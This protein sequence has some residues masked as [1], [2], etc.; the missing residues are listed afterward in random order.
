[1][2]T[3]LV[4]FLS[5]TREGAAGAVSLVIGVMSPSYAMTSGKYKNL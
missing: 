1:M 5:T 2:A 4:Q 3:T